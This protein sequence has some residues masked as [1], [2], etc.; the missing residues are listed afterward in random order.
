M[1]CLDWKNPYEIMIKKSSS[2]SLLCRHQK[3]FFNGKLMLK[4]NS[5]FKTLFYC[6]LLFCFVLYK[7]WPALTI[8]NYSVS[9]P[10]GD[11]LGTMAWISS[12]HEFADK[13]GWPPLLSS[14]YF[15]NIFFG[16]GNNGGAWFFLPWRIIYGG[17]SVFLL[18]NQVYDLVAAIGIFLTATCSFWLLRILKVDH[19]C[20]FLASLIIISLENTAIR[21]TGHLT[22]SFFFGQ[23][24]VIVGLLQWFGNFRFRWGLFIVFAS[25]ISLSA[26][27]YYAFYG[28]I[29]A[30]VFSA[31]YLVLTKKI[32]LIFS[33]QNIF[34]II[35]LL[36]L[37]FS[38]VYF[39]MPGMFGGGAQVVSNRVQIFEY[40]NFSLV[41][42]FQI[43]SSSWIEKYITFPKP[44]LLTNTPE[45]TFRIGFLVFSM[46]VSA[47]IFDRF[48]KKSVVR[49]PVFI[50]LFVASVFSLLI[51]L[52]TNYFPF[53]S[54]K[55]IS[56]FPMFRVISRSALFFDLGIILMLFILIQNILIFRFKNLALVLITYLIL[57]DLSPNRDVFSPYGI[58]ELP[59]PTPSLAKLANEPDGLLA[60]LPL[61][62]KE[63]APEVESEIAYRRLFHKKP[64]L[65]I[66]R[67]MIPSKFQPEHERL[68]DL[69]LTSPDFLI[70]E[71]RDRHVRYL[72]I[73]ESLKK[74]YIGNSQLVLLAEDP[75]F[76]AY[77]ILN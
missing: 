19:F 63:M 14:K 1:K 53:I 26:N 58:F 2:I 46:F 33:H 67:S 45:F 64:L 49:S 42:P 51:C 52:P 12:I 77:K 76:S 30:F 59:S 8:P 40:N 43:I 7:F 32:H 31:M 21:L 71:L 74:Y 20:A 22:L 61:I 70:R 10:S 3:S 25:I 65:N 54:K 15:D 38:M 17:L 6:S 57:I 44:E 62:K 18:P 9:A 41:D 72:L 5:N 16:G 56:I 27:E 4:I 73:N 37:L 50:A 68:A 55:L 75:Y 39:L 13:M 47:S 34:K 11:G 48:H 35:V 28:G 24:L 23:I 60:E 36:S 69:Q 29:F 66:I